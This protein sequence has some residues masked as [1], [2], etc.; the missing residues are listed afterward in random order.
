M[1]PLFKVNMSPVANEK[2][3]ETLS[4]GFVTQGPRVDELEAVSYQYLNLPR[5]PVAVNS[6]TSALDLAFDLAGIEPGDEV[7]STPMTC[8][9]TNAGL[10]RRGAKIVWADVYPF[11]GNISV[12]DVER[13]A[14]DKTKAIVGVNWAGQF[15]EYDALK[16]L[17]PTVIEDAAHTWDAYDHNMPRGDYIA[18]S[19]QAIKFLT[20][21]DGGLLV[22]PE[23][24]H[25]LARMKRWYG[26]DRDNNESFRSMQD[27]NTIG[28][29]YNMNDISATIALANMR[30]AA[31]G[32]HVHRNNA[33]YMYEALKDL[34]W[35]FVPP[36]YKDTSYWIFPLVVNNGIDRDDFERYLNANGIQAAQ[37]HTR[38]DKYSVT[39]EFD[40]RTLPGLDYFSTHQTN[41]PCGWWL[42]N[43]DTDFI[44]ESIRRYR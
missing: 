12:F 27:I 28:Y 10:M 33:K 39:K 31:M 13:V 8:Y 15:A 37:V 22:T 44:I 16:L 19:L 2:V 14:T 21:G 4:S 23:E 30:S 24:T 35:L 29:K 25:R 43:D 32:V 1:I 3:A 36:Y 20:A 5:E 42:T 9:A 7:I 34:D 11:T 18:Y 40:T 38:N 6:A 17:A 41:V 26:L